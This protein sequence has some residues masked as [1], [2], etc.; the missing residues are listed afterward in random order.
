MNND[1]FI[2]A[3]LISLKNNIEFYESMIDASTNPYE[4]MYYKHL[5]NCEN[6][7]LEYYQNYAPTK[8][9]MDKPPYQS[10]NSY[11]AFNQN[12][13]LMDRLEKQ[14]RMIEENARL[15]EQNER[16]EEA[17]IEFI[18]VD[19][20]TKSIPIPQ[21][22]SV[23]DTDRIEFMLNL[24]RI[25]QEGKIVQTD[26][27]TPL[28]N[29]HVNQLTQNGSRERVFTIEELAQFNGSNG[30]PAYVA[31]QGIVYDVNL[32]PTWGGGT[33]FSLFAGKDLTDFYLG[34]HQGNLNAVRKLPVVGRLQ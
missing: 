23:N 15:I 26:I 25:N 7:S 32:E 30:K 19:H 29:S 1:N 20:I 16:Q 14:K 18:K 10:K 11:L 9:Y 34:C 12:I 31:I 21:V 13:Q 27:D 4:K 8:G 17:N 6:S 2:E 24:S 28:S 3:K 5:L 33:H 22:D